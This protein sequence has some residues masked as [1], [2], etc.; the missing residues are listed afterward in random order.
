MKKSS[1]TINVS[2]KQAELISSLL[3]EHIIK[4]N[5]KRLQAVRNES[6]EAINKAWEQ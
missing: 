6:T 5:E 1:I 3:L 2:P 4:M